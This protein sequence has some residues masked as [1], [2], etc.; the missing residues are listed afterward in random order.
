MSL[1][2][3]ETKALADID[4]YG[5]H[6]IHVAAEGE[7]P[8]FSYSVGI[9]RSS[10]R[11]EVVVVGLK[12]NL[13]HFVVNE[14]NRRAKGGEIFTPGAQYGE[15]ID[16]FDVTFEE[17]EPEFYVDY[18]GWDLWL[19]GG[20]NFEVLQLVY[21]TTSGEWPWQSSESDW[22]K[23]RQPIL[24]TTPVCAAKYP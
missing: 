15:F 21:P 12:Q 9:C 5:C 10:E 14:Y 4:R 7:L 23:K 18:F 8:P 6:V 13:A 19:Y 17:V 1:D 11:P 16:G 3:G 24:T 20:P 22:F 2:P